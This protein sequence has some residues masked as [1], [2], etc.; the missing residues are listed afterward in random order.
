MIYRFVNGLLCFALLVLSQSLIAKQEQATLV[1]TGEMPLI[2]NSQTGD[3]S[4]LASLLT[5]IRQQD[6]NTSF[7]F[8]GGSLGPSPM[9]AFDRGSHIIDILNTLE[10]DVMAVSKRE[11]S[12]FEEELS[13][14]SYEAAFPI[15]ASNVILPGSGR[16]LDGLTDQLLIEKGGLKLGVISVLDQTVVKEYLLTRVSIS[17]PREAII[18]RATRLKLLGADLVVL[19]YSENLPFIDELLSQETI[20]LAL[21]TDPHFVLSQKDEIPTHPNSVYLTEAGLAA[22]ITVKWQGQENKVFD[23]SWQAHRL[24]QQDAEPKV[25]MQIADYR[26]RLDRLL[27]EKVGVLETPMDTR[28]EI[29]RAEESAFANFVADALRD[30][31]TT[32]LA[33]INGGVIRGERQYKANTALTRR[34]IAIELPFRSRIVII[35][36][37]GKALKQAIENGLSMIEEYKGR[38]LH[39]SGASVVFDSRAKVGKRVQQVKVN[40]ELIKDYKLYQVATSDYLAAGGDEFSMLKQ[41]KVIELNTR[42]APLMSEVVINQIRQRRHIAPMIEG[43]LLDIAKGDQ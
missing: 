9:S 35:E 1:F 36:I 37:T 24:K 23:I 17:D 14:R 15:L 42:V 39:L 2:N 31:F 41:A 30:F 10:P 8:S 12:Y 5:K 6:P 38:F 32:D 3:Y 13:L 34:D 7:L 20:D 43:R 26:A 29:V 19:M 33:L 4:E 21:L 16:I 40:G 25:Q 18:D 11:F 27:D 28:R 22:E